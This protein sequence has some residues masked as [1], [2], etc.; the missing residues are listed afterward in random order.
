MVEGVASGGKRERF[1]QAP[2]TKA[3]AEWQAIDKRLPPH[4]VARRIDRLVSMLDLGPLWQSYLGVG[5][6]ALPA[7]LLLKAV[8]FEMHVKRP[9]PA[10][11]ARDAVENEPLR[12][13]LRGLKPSRASL[14]AFRDRI[15]PFLEEWN[16]QVLLQALQEGMTTVQRVALDSTTVAAHAS[17]RQLFS[18]TRLRKREQA[19]D[20]RLK[21]LQH[22]GRSD[23]M[24]AKPTW[25]AK[26]SRGL[27]LQKRRC[28]L[29]AVILRQRQHANQLRPYNERKPVERIRVSPGDPAAILMRDKENVFRPLYTVE[30]VR[31]LD[32][33]LVLDYSVWL[34]NNENG[35]LETVM[36]RL[37]DHLAIKPVEV[38]VD[39]GYVSLT[40]LEFCDQAGI[41]LYGPHK[42]NDYSKVTGKKLQSNQYTQLPK[43]AFTWL[44]EEQ[45][46][47]CPEGHYM[48]Y[49]GTTRQRRAQ[50]AITLALYRCSPAHCQACPRQEACTKTPQQGRTVSRLANEHL[51]DRLRQR[52]QTP[53][54]KELYRLR[55]QTVER[56]HADLK[57]H[58]GIRR[59]HGRGLTRAST[60]I[61]TLVLVHNLLELNAHRQRPAREPPLE[62]PNP[63][64]RCIA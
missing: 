21:L 47:R 38:L 4:H 63:P 15:A 18:E 23:S 64:T 7:D 24:L 28:E 49:V 45:V 26:T 55:S 40:A 56:N 1:I 3:S 14:Y 33:P 11:W 20:E 51:V 48:R 53:A 34:Q 60:E 62:S 58:R 12:W 46:Y 6:K 37:S 61:G 54:A 31:D 17:R 41:T 42:E 22:G 16:V 19:I 39:A 44:E 8:L 35:V 2:W 9:S 57:E 13:L 25:L 29:A 5:K 50:N 52:M 36:E 27:R 32:S 10:Q 30:L 59:F 43:R